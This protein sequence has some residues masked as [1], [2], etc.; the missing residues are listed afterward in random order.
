MQRRLLAADALPEPAA[1]GAGRLPLVAAL[2]LVPAAGAAL[3][4]VHGRPDLPAAPLA[5]RVQAAAQTDGLVALLRQ[6]LATPGLDP[7]RAREGYVLLG[8]TEDTMG[9]LP[10]AAAAWRQA[11]R[12]RFDAGLAALAA[13]AQTRIDGHVGPDAAALFARALAEGPK[14][15][16]WRAVAE[17]RMQQASAAK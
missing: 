9:D 10:A 2:L 4:L 6:R 17:Q 5:A 3:Y 7:E 16:P 12:L 14:D 13:E 1:T 11:V 15:A 8:N